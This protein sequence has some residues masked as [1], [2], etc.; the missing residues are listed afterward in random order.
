MFNP[1]AAAFAANKV[2]RE[3]TE[4]GAVG[5][6]ETENLNL[7][8]TELTFDIPI[9]DGIAGCVFDDIP[10]VPVVGQ[11]YKVDWNG[12]K[13]TCVCKLHGD[14]EVSIHYIGNSTIAYYDEN[15]TGEPF[16]IQYAV[17]DGQGTFSV[18][19][20][21]GLT[22][23]TV[24]I[25]TETETIHPIDPKFLP[26]DVIGFPVTMLNIVECGLPSLTVL[27]GRAIQNG[28]TFEAEYDVHGLWETVLGWSI[29]TA[30]EGK[31]SPLWF[32]DGQ[33]TMMVTGFGQKS[34][35]A[36]GCYYAS[37]LLQIGCVLRTE[38]MS[39][40][41]KCTVSVFAKAV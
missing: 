7:L 11:L 4:S 41:D 1:E 10:F 15:D 29:G 6:A 32:T 18:V 22:T 35:N 16:I 25:T 23:A 2:L 33:N 20:N 5:Y 39:A 12:V 9:E 8:S 21:S 13:Y 24:S 17:Q 34:I 14:E 40:S 38:S 37:G 26:L 30:T 28:G 3:L 31:I 36:I 19:T 27:I